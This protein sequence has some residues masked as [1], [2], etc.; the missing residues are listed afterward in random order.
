MKTSTTIVLLVLALC[1][2]LPLLAQSPSAAEVL[3]SV[4]ALAHK[5]ATAGFPA[6]GTTYHF[7]YTVSTEYRDPQPNQANQEQ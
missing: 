4:K 5:Q 7:K 6:V 2:S 3:H 1:G